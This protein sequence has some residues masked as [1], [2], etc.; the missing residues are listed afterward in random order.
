MYS[1]HKVEF[2]ILGLRLHLTIKSDAT[3][4]LVEAEFGFAGMEKDDAA[5]ETDQD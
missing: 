3:G 4:P 5:E 2:G 1:Q